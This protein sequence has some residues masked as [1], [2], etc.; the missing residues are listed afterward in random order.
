[1]RL[2][3]RTLRIY[4]KNNFSNNNSEVIKSFSRVK[5]YQG[6]V[7][8][9]KTLYAPNWKKYPDQSDCEVYYECLYVG[10][11]PYTQLC[12]TGQVFDIDIEGCVRP[13]PNF[14]CEYRCRTPATSAATDTTESLTSHEQQQLRNK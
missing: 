10:F 14:A 7:Q 11:P 5:K 13:T 9:M 8:V 3:C 4:N 6:T 12:E 1:M 2:I